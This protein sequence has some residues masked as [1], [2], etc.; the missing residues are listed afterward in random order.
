MTILV[1][2]DE[3][4]TELKVRVPGAAVDQLELELRATLRE[5]FTKSG[6]WMEELSSIN[7]KEGK[8]LYRLNYPQATVM[9]VHYAWINGTPLSLGT[10]APKTTNPSGSASVAF[11]A[12]SNLMQLFPMPSTDMDDAL[13]I[14][15]RLNPLTEMCK[16]PVE[17][18]TH[19]FDEIMD[20]VLGRLYGMPSKPYTNLLL[21]QYH[22]RRFRDGISTAR[23]MG[24]RRFSTAT[25]PW[26]FPGGWGNNKFGGGR[27]A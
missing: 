5:F 25:R 14:I 7:I 11:M 18:V 24:R 6:W 9:G 10:Q 13:K 19:F 1:N 27:V 23:D 16:V 4:A 3:W 2:T 8:D 12:E 26:S 21:S 20:G 17:T 22:L 15:V